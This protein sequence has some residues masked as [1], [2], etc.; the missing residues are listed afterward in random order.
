MWRM[1][2]FLDAGF[3]NRIVNRRPAAGAGLCD[4]V[5]VCARIL[6]EGLDNLRLV[7]KGHHKS[8]ILVAAEHT[9]KEINRSILLKFDAVA[10]A[11]RGV[12]KHADPQGKIRLL[13]EKADFLQPVFVENLEVAL[14]QIRNQLVAAV[15]HGE[16][17]VNEVDDRDDGLFALLRRFLVRRRRRGWRAGR[18]LA[19]RSGLLRPVAERK[20]KQRE[21]QKDG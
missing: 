9:E 19:V 2:Q 18:W 11:V 13:A 15:Q 12:Q 20:Q 1:A 14:L 3:I 7:V 17:H 8:F 5:S 21:R 10:D 4:L 16:K 6:G